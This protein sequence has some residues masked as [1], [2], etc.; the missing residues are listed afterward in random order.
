MAREIHIPYGV[1]GSADVYLRFRN[2][3]GQYR[4]GDTGAYETYNAVNI[5]LYG[6]D[7]GSVTPYYVATE[8]GATG[9][10]FA[11]LPDVTARTWSAYLQAGAAPLESD[12][13]IAADS[14]GVNTTQL[15]G[16]LVNA[17]A[18]VTFPASVGDATAANQ[19]TILARLGA[20][21]GSGINS[22][23]GAFIALF[24]KA[25]S[26][27]SDITGTMNPATASVEALQEA[28]DAAPTAAEIDTQLSGAHGAG[29]WG[30]SSGSGSN[31][32]QFEITNTS[33][34]LLETATITLR[35][36]GILKAT[37]TTDETGRLTGTG[38]AVA[39]TGT[40]ELSVT[41]EGYNGHT[42]DLVVT[43]GVNTMVEVE[44]TAL[45][46]SIPAETDP[47]KTTAY[48]YVYGSDSELVGLNDVTLTIEIVELPADRGRAYDDT[49]ISKSSTAAG[50]ITASLFKGAKYKVILSDDREW[51]VEV[52]LTAG[53]TYRMPPIRVVSA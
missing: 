41:C 32:I 46:A 6:A 15:A 44:L 11:D 51:F 37:G 3:S 52:P 35:L 38:L 24:S 43:A 31:T 39:A 49:P 47:A 26:K 40:Y 4:R 25:A 36:N 13:E 53:T 30:S 1:T 27:P 29:A 45:G 8:D 17:A 5:A 2:A 42:A 10:Y 22:I 19:T 18:P 33:A 34:A 23:L 9:D 50:E 21:T 28:I 48:W 14:L 16:Q 12:V 7:A 20:W